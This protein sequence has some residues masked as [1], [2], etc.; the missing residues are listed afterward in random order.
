MHKSIVIFLLGLLA[1]LLPFGPSMNTSN[2]MA[3]TEAEYYTDQYLEYANDMVNEYEDEPSYAND[4]YKSDRS[5]YG[6]NN[7]NDREYPSYKQDDRS[8]G[9][10]DKYKS[11]DKNS[12]SVSLS[13]INCNSVNYNVLGDVTG[14]NNIGNDGTAAPNSNGALSTNAYGSNG[15]RYNDGYQKERGI[16]CQINNDNSIIAAT[17]GEIDPCAECFEPLTPAQIESVAGN[18]LGLPPGSPEAVEAICN[19]LS[20]NDITETSFRAFLDFA[21]VSTT[22]Q[23]TLITCLEGAGVVFI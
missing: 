15:E 14:D 5:S 4:G 8:Y 9:Y 1:F 18:L 2:A 19:F 11:K 12:N 3:I 21:G 6:N 16:T 7:Y 13:K 20:E 17:D 23:N 10:D 22:V